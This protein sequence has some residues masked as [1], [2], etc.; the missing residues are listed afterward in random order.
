MQSHLKSH[1][2]IRDCE[3][4][5]PTFCRLENPSLTLRSPTVDCP[6]CPKKFSRRHDRARHCAAVHDSHIPNDHARSAHDE[7]E[8][9]FEG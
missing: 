8:E 9:A 5:F 1:L 4:P 2:G 7:D 6:H 3:S